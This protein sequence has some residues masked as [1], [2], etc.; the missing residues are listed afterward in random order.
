MFLGF[1]FVMSSFFYFKFIYKKNVRFQ[2]FTDNYHIY[3]K[4]M[5]LPLCT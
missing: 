3:T 5:H 1:W 4:V 2:G